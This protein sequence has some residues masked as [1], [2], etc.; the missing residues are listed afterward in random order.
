MNNEIKEVCNFRLVYDQ[1]TQKRINNFERII[2]DYIRYFKRIN[3]HLPE[4][5]LRHAIL[6]DKNIRTMQDNLN[7][8]YEN[9]IAIGVDYE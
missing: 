8:I 2:N 3:S 1:E 4:Y 6:N 7:K 9:A 5:N